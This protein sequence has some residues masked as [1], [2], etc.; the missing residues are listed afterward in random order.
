MLQSRLTT[1][2]QLLSYQNTLTR[3]DIIYHA[4]HS[5]SQPLRPRPLPLN[6]ILPI[7]P[8]KEI[9]LQ[10]IKRLPRDPLINPQQAIKRLLGH[11]AIHELR[12]QHLL[13][14][15]QQRTRRIP[16]VTRRQLLALHGREKISHQHR[17]FRRNS[18]HSLGSRQRRRVA[19]RPDVWVARVL[20]S[21]IGDGNVAC[22]VGERAGFDERPGYVFGRDVQEIKVFFYGC[23]GGGGGEGGR[24]AGDGG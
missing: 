13:P 3:R 21:G 23:G 19:N 18:R 5:P 20:R 12:K 22:V 2:R 6:M 7:H 1:P 15:R 9:L 24:V 8:R 10:P 11:T 14:A 4:I 16:I 17:R